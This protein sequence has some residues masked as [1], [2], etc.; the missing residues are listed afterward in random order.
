MRAVI[1]DQRD[2]L[3]GEL[4]DLSALMGHPNPDHA[5]RLLVLVHAGAFQIAELDNSNAVRETPR[6][7]PSTD[8]SPP[9]LADAG[10]PSRDGSLK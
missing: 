5:A 9:R 3:F 8:C 1:Y 4:S 7:A 10:P 6:A 2:W